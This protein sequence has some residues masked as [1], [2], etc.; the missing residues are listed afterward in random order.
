MPGTAGTLET[1][2]QQIAL[3]LQPLKD[4]L[5]SG[6][7]IQLFAALGLQSPPQLLQ[8]SFVNALNTGAGAAGALPATITQLA[9]AIDNDDESGILSAGVQLIQE[10]GAI[11]AALEQIGTELKN[12]SGTLPGMNATEVTDFAQSLASNLL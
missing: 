7:I 12:I 5:A 4:R 3:A 8:P 10:I 2:A 6:P 1:I 11:I 9:T